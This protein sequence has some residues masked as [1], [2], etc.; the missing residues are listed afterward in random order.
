MVLAF[1][2]GWDDGHRA[3]LVADALVGRRSRP[4]VISALIEK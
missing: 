4:S 1:A 2:S 3:R